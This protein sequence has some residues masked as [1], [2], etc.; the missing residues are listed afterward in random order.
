MISICG[1]QKFWSSDLGEFLITE[2]L[3][4]W[5]FLFGTKKWKSAAYEFLIEMYK[6]CLIIRMSTYWP[7]KLETQSPP[8][9]LLVQTPK[10][11]LLAHSQLPAYVVSPEPEPLFNFLYTEL[12]C[13]ENVS[14]F[15]WGWNLYMQ[16]LCYQTLSARAQRC[17]NCNISRCPHVLFQCATE[18]PS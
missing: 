5:W 10:L 12:C 6:D 3:S 11:N 1:G 9:R 16:G 14:V 18:E 15:A 7:D 13:G 17:L 8:C 2:A 4:F